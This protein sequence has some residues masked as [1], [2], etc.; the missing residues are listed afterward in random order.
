MTN[1]INMKNIVPFLSL[2]FLTSCYQQERKCT[3][4]KTGKFQF[5]QEIQGV[6]EMS[7]FER[8]DTVQ[9]ETF[10]GKTDTSTVRWI[11]DCEFIL[12]KLHPKGMRDKKGIHMKFLTTT[13]DSYTFEYSYVGESNKMKGTVK[14][15]N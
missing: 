10:R 12:N 8:N 5:E 4:F 15:I 7:V 11:N 6:K 3:D 13:D 1:K 14:K 2:L 9:I